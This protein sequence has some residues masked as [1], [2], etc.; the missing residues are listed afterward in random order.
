MEALAV[1]LL[2]VATAW[3]IGAAARALD[4]SIPG[5]ALVG[6]VVL[7]L[8]P[9]PAAYFTKATFAP[10]RNPYLNDI[11]TQV[12]P[13]TEAV[14]LA[15]REGSLPWR[16]RWNGC[17]TPLAANSVSAAFF[18]VT[19]ATMLFPLWRG[20]ALA[21]AVKLLL[22]ASG[23]WLWARELGASARAAAFAAV[24]FALSFSFLPPWILYPQSGVFCLWPWMLFLIERCRDRRGYARAVTGL[25]A[26]FVLIVLAGHPE[27]AAL[28]A[29][30]AAALLA[31]RFAIGDLPKLPR[32]ARAIAVAA[33]VAIGLT[34]FLLVPSVLAI[35]ASARLAMAAR[36]YWQPHLSLRPHGPFWAAILPAVFPHT[37]GNATW[38]PTVAGGTGTFT[39]MAMGY[40]GILC[41][42]AA[43]LVFRPGSPRPR[44]EKVLWAIALVGFGEAVCLWP[45]AEIFARLPLLRYVF[46]LRFNAWVALALPAIA[47]LELDRYAHDVRDHRRAA[48]GLAAVA[49]ALGTAAVGLYAYLIGLRRANGDLRAQT[50]QLAV[51][52]AVLGLAGLV[53]LVTRTRP[54]TLVVALAILCTGELLYQ[55]HGL[56]RVYDHALYYPE[57]PLLRFLREQPGTFRVTGRGPALFPSSNVFARLE[58]VRTHDAVE[59]RDYL[60]FLDRTC[61]YR[62]DEYFKT[63]G[64]LEAP[65]LDFLNVRFLLA[66]AGTEAPGPRWRSVY[67]GADGR[68][69]ENATV[70]P[71]AFA[72]ARIRRVEPPPAGVGPVLDAARAF[73]PAFAD[74]A[75]N[76][77]WRGTAWIL[78]PG[79]GEA[80]NP[81]VA[82]SDYSES[83]NAASFAARVADGGS[84]AYVVLSLV[85]DGGWTAR[86]ENGRALPTFLAN[87]P[88]LALRLEPGAHRAELTYR[89][90]GLALG[91]A[92][93]AATAVLVAVAVVR[94]RRRRR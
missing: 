93:S 49:A 29:V 61:G 65:A 71:R 70:L 92:V 88:F 31:G 9:Y 62:S 37:L 22:A 53:A 73:G 78:A 48:V 52:L 38:A 15:F 86:D 34:A 72:P 58:D 39:E 46:P 66:Q 23:M 17:G 67:E 91:S 11:A 69:F 26:V 50:W 13:W 40:A 79:G 2:L 20:F 89:P 45:I 16:D 33:T 42:L 6:F 77:D 43:L 64:N 25:T 51:V 59:R 27:S 14:R 1:L 74:V 84:P 41:W 7:S 19:L 5:A 83:T 55:W 68:V 4:R 76:A 24:A 63:L 85:Q 75:A 12:L 82:V 57:T 3:G 30:F 36:P 47:A 21:V 32:E 81:E 54:E 94:R 90:P 56:H 35:G 8:L 60:E 28:G 80:A 10:P 18:P 87:G 44:A